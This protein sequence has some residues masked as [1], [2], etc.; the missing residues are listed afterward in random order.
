MDFPHSGPVQLVVH[1]ASGGSCSSPTSRLT[2][3]LVTSISS[4]LFRSTRIERGTFMCQGAVQTTPRSFPL[5][6][7]RAMCFTTPRFK[8]RSDSPPRGNVKARPVDRRAAEVLDPRLAS[9]GPIIQLL[10]CHRICQPSPFRVE[11]H[12]PG[13]GDLGDFFVARE[14]PS[15]LCFERG[16]LV[17]EHDKVALRVVEFQWDGCDLPIIGK[18]GESSHASGN[19]VPEF[20]LLSGNSKPAG[21]RPFLVGQVGHEI[22][23]RVRPSPMDLPQSDRTRAICDGKVLL[24]PVK[25]SPTAKV[26][27]SAASTSPWL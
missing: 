25:F 14:I 18:L 15:L 13:A 24:R 3:T 27:G 21:S 23:L 1:S 9:L 12:T 17:P 16:R 11:R 8:Y 22:D 6:R 4:L 26:P 5:T 19:R 7:T 20:R 2:H 10:E